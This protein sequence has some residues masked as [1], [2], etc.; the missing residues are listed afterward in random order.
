M[1]ANLKLQHD[2]NKSYLQFLIVIN[3]QFLL[4]P[5]SRICNIELHQKINAILE[6]N[7]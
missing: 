4:T 1:H 6:S 5:C 2:I 3:F 7:S